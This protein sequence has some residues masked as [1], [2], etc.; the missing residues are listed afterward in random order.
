MR[1]VGGKFKRKALKAP[2]GLDV[3]PT[4]DRTR[5]SVFNVLEH[6]IEDFTLR[7]VSVLDVFAGTGALGLEALSRGALHATLID[8]DPRSLQ[9]ARANAGALGAARLVTLLKLD[10]TALPPPPLAAQAPCGLAFLDPPYRSG[11]ANDA[12]LKLR[13]RGWIGPGS[14]GVVS[15][16]ADETLEA[17]KKY[18]EID[19]RTYGAAQVVFLRVSP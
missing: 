7:D 1:I 3:R 13:D 18:A 15:L 19:R 9:C 11:L 8:N 14:V 16:A 4:A 5:E 2:A 12:L 17:P 6:G 10:A